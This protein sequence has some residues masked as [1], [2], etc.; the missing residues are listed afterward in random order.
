MTRMA[1]RMTR[2]VYGWR[3]LVLPPVVGA[4]MLNPAL[5]NMHRD[6][7]NTLGQDGIAIISAAFKAALAGARLAFGSIASVGGLSCIVGCIWALFDR[8]DPRGHVLVFAGLA[9]VA[10]GGLLPLYAY[11]ASAVYFVVVDALDSVI[12]MGRRA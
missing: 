3:W 9:L 6:E 2:W 12:R 5:L 1:L 8:E 11:I 10:G 7:R 4:L